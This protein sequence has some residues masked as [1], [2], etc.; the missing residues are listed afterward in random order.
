ME[1][2]LSK[3]FCQVLSELMVTVGKK[4]AQEQRKLYGNWAVGICRS[5]KVENHSAARS[6]VLL[7][8]NLLPASDDLVIAREMASELL[9]VIGSEDKDPTD[10]SETF[11]VI[12][13]STK[14]VIATMMMQLVEFSIADLDWAVSRLKAVSTFGHEFASPNGNIQFG[15]RL[16]GLLLEEAIYS[17]S[18]A[19]VDVMSS[20]TE[21]NL[22][23]IFL[24]NITLKPRELSA[25]CSK[26]L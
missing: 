1:T 24:V 23:G 14:N 18:E 11:L 26:P 13:H 6:L 20:F 19:L 22:K 5:H 15:E 12:N 16:P 7:A 25:L 17:R 8:L 4:L 3:F 10:M 9:K 2:N 21:M